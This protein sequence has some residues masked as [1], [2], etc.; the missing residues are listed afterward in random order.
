MCVLLAREADEWAQGQEMAPV[1]LDCPIGSAFN[2]RGLGDGPA[3]V[4]A[5]CRP[6][7]FGLGLVVPAGITAPTAI[8]CTVLW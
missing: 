6:H 1:Q 2:L 5:Q 3:A 4:Y 8:L 7:F